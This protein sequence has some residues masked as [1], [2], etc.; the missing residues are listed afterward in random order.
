MILRNMENFKVLGYDATYDKT[1]GEMV[2]YQRKNK[3]RILKPY[4]DRG[5]YW[6]YYFKVDG[7]NK[8]LPVHRIIGLQFL[9]NPEEKEF[10]DHINRNRQDNRLENLRWAT[11]TENSRNNERKGYCFHKKANKWKVEVCCKYYGLYETEEEARQRANEIK[12]L[13]GKL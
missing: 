10:I 12:K 4:I 7:K 5:G 8:N 11:R 6:R 1:T 2:V 9:P 13:I 3:G